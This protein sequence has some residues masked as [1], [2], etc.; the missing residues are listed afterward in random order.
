VHPNDLCVSQLSMGRYVAFSSQVAMGPH[1][2]CASSV[3]SSPS[4]GSC[5]IRM[6][7]I[8][9]AAGDAIRGAR[10]VCQGVIR[11]VGQYAWGWGRGWLSKDAHLALGPAAFLAT[12]SV[13]LLAPL[14]AKHQKRNA[15]L[16]HIGVHNIYYG[17]ALRFAMC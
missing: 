6:C 10:F 1:A 2:H 16:D 9:C 13:G 3:R 11:G 4:E 8:G 15:L 5:A 14:H 12:S 17:S 7:A